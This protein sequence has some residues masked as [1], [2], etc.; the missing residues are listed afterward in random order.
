MVPIAHGSDIGGSIR[1]PASLCGG[2]GLKPSRGRVS[3]GPVV[4]EGGFGYSMNFIQCKTVRDAAAMLDCLAHPQ[5][6]DP[7]II[8]KPAEPY[9]ALAKRPAPK[10]RIGMV[11]DEL[12]G[13]KVDP[14]V[15]QAVEAAGKALAE[16]P[17]VK[18]PS[19]TS[20]RDGLGPLYSARAC[21][22]CHAK[23]GRGAPPEDE[24]TPLRR[25]V[26]RL[27]IPGTDERDGAVPEPSYGLQLQT[28]ST[29]LRDELRHRDA[30]RRGEDAANLLKNGVY[31]VSEGANM[32]STPEA[33]AQF[34]DRGILFGPGKA[35]NAGGVAVSGLE[36]SQNSSRW[37]WSREEVDGKLQLI[38]KRIHDTCLDAEG[39]ALGLAAEAGFFELEGEGYVSEGEADRNSPRHRIWYAF[40]PADET[41]EEKPLAVL[42]NGGPG[43]TGRSFSDYDTIVRSIRERLF[44][45]PDETTV[46]T[47]HGDSTTI[48]AE[49]A[50]LGRQ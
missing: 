39:R 24:S 37:A 26:L 25:G 17:W 32:P 44:R 45:L 9:A 4:D 36:M 42:F 16:Q 2:V 5:P 43:A 33:V 28:R 48:G 12:V 10:L 49:A 14:E 6:G 22:D 29:S 47:G 41:P 31:V 38:M 18:A 46:H 3:I 27:S 19:I 21:F 7:F 35:A 20:A 15:A 1:I 13:V 23:G 30:V 34:V 40:Q 11:L 50:G 8:A